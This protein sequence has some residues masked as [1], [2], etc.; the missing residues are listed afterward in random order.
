MGIIGT[1]ADA[2]DP[3]EARAS[4][5][6]AYVDKVE[7]RNHF[8]FRLQATAAAASDPVIADE[9]RR[10]FV[11]GFERL[12]EITGDDRQAVKT[13]I[14]IGLFA[15]VAMAIGLPREYWPALPAG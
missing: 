7:Y 3:V 9:A 15:D 11:E 8:L 4:I 2:K 1:G 6:R 10:L 5:Q 14:S 12:L 13:Y